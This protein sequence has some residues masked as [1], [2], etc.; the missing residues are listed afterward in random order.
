MRKDLYTI[1][2]GKWPL[3]YNRSNY[4][5]IILILIPVLHLINPERAH[6]Q[7]RVAAHIQE[8][9]FYAAIEGDTARINSLADARIDLDIQIENGLTPLIFAIVYEQK[10]AAELLI[11]RGADPNL[12]SAT[13]ESPLMTAIKIGNMTIAEMVI[14]NGGDINQR[15]INGATAL[16]YSALYGYFYESDMLLYYDANPEIAAN[17]GTT[18]LMCAV[19]SAS[20]DIADILIRSGADVNSVDNIGYTPLLIAAQNGDTLTMDLLLLSGADLYAVGDD[21]YNAAGIAVRGNFPE[22]LDY[23]LRQGRL[24][25]IANEE[26]HGLWHVAG[27][28]QRRNMISIIQEYNI[29]RGTLPLFSQLAVSTSLL[30]SKHQSFAGIGINVKQPLYGTGLVIG[31]D[32]NPWRSRILIEEDEWITQYE[33]TRSLAYLGFSW[34]LPLGSSGRRTFWSLNTTLKAAYMFGN[35][36]PGSDIRPEHKI[37][38][39]PSAGIKADIGN[40]QTTVSA[41]YI[42]T[43]IYKGRPLFGRVTVGYNIHFNDIRSDGKEIRWR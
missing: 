20:Y 27:S 40:I 42:N 1:S 5:L 37:K 22:A 6:T 29:K 12:S 39:I 24:W 19:I 4:R 7:Q 25:D 33:D 41:E 28:Y 3:V 43:E 26:A 14:R 2:S 36:F 11:R 34:D 10:E 35:T 16:H 31:I 13:G 18:P 30:A 38:I 32:T 17:D 21:S 9:L 15:D 8:A 23:L